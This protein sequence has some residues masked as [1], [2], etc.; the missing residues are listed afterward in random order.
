MGKKDFTFFEKLKFTLVI[1][2]FFLFIILIIGEVVLRSKN[3]EKPFTDKSTIDEE[4][5]W[6]LKPNLNLKYKVKSYKD[7]IPPYDVEYK[8]DA[9]GFRAYGDASSN[10]KKVFFVGDSYI[11][12][13]EVSNSK[14]FY[15]LLK[16]SL[17]IEVFAYGH[18]GYGTLQEKMVIDRFINQIKPDLIVLATCDN[19]FIDNY[20]PLE[21]NSTYKV[22]IRR[23]YYDLSG[24][25]TY[26]KAMPQW[27]ELIDKSLFL[28]LIR[29]KLS[30]SFFKS[31]KPSSQKLITELQREYSPYNKSIE[32]T[33]KI[34]K[35]LKVSL[36]GTK[37]IA[38]STSAFEPQLS[39]MSNIF[40]EHNIPFN[41]EVSLKM[42]KLKWNNIPI[43]S[44]DG[45]HWTELGHQKVA[46]YL[47]D[48]IL[49]ALKNQK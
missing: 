9:Q 32:I 7:L 24:N 26:R 46:E 25:I 5:G 11:Q 8:T 21:Y 36:N 48:S 13:V 23:P 42:K 35:D 45:Y 27:Q 2:L 22:G 38:F 15:N 14:L 16:D 28:G 6:A 33:N 39:H 41:K 1:I 29:R 49:Q 43:H 12:S 3:E 37:I 47:K 17:D 34:I 4:L 10:K 19:D 30:N 44:V 31:T 18:A 20:A 40:K